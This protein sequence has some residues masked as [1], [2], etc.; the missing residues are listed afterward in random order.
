MKDSRYVL[1]LRSHALAFAVVL[2]PVF[3]Q[4]YSCDRGDTYLLS[5]Q[6]EVGGQDLIQGFNPNNRSGYAVTPSGSIATLTV[7]TRMDDS[8]ATY[9]WIVAGTTIEAG[10]IGE[11][12]GSVV[13]NVPLGQSRLYIGVRAAEGNVDGYSVDV[14]NLSKAIAETIPMYCTVTGYGYGFEGTDF[15]LSVEALDPV[16]ATEAFQAEISGLV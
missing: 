7:D 15:H 4:A 3:L 12:G 11:G 13:L 10:V 5:L 1:Q 8:T 16:I 2:S 9:Q 6:L 14:D